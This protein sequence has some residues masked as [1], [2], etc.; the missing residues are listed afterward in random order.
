MTPTST[1]A[2]RIVVFA[3]GRANLSPAGRRFD[4]PAGVKVV[5]VPCTGRVS[6]PLLVG[7]IAEGLDGILVLGRHQE[8]CRFNGAEDAVV[9]RCARASR[10]FGLVNIAPERVRFVDPA[11]GP[12]GPRVAV[13]DFV[14]SIAALDAS[15]LDGAVASSRAWHHE[16]LDGLLGALAALAKE[17][18]G[19]GEAGARGREQDTL[20]ATSFARWQRDEDL[21]APKVGGATLLAGVLPLVTLAAGDLLRPV[22]AQGILGSAVAVLRHLGVEAGVGSYPPHDGEGRVFALRGGLVSGVEAFFQGG[23]EGDAPVTPLESRP[24]ESRP[25]QA[26]VEDVEAFVAQHAA[27]IPRPVAPRKVA[28][29]SADDVYLVEALGYE[30][31]TVD[32]YPLPRRFTLSPHERRDVARYLEGVAARGAVAYYCGDLVEHLLW[33]AVTRHGAWQTHTL[34][35][36][37]AA[38]LASLSLARLPLSPTFIAAPPLFSGGRQVQESVA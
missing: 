37:S 4:F 23:D 7:G 9:D 20:V 16:S 36:V 13:E 18:T 5:E 11:P 14:T 3:C 19:A 34:L 30:A 38:Q 22:S 1:S 8:T 24:A 17:T 32:P 15:H 2:R 35:P 33:A 10:L 31:L 27:A 6:L 25:G 28:C 21:P 26:P 12:E 29:M